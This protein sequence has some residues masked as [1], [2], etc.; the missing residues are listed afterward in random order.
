MLSTKDFRIR[1]PFILAHGESGTYYL[2]GTTDENVW[3]GPAV[4]FDVYRSRDLAEW[5]GPFPAFRP[6]PGFWA[7]RQFWAPEVFAYGGRYYM[8]ASFKAE[9][10][11]RGTQVL[12]A[13]GPSGPY[14][15]LTGKPLTPPDWE[16]L[17]GTLYVD[18]DGTPWMVFC[19]EWLQVRDGKMCAVP[20]TRDLKER[21]G[22][23]VVLFA[24]SSAPWV[25]PSREGNCVTDGPFLY[26][27]EDGQ[28]L[29]LWSSIGEKGY[30]MGIAR[31]E[32][33]TVTG[34]WVHD[35]EPLFGEDGGHGMLFRTFGGELAM[36]IHAPNRS[37]H[38]RAVF[39]P[40]REEALLRPSGNHE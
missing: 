19:Q 26:R 4:G 23:P 25:R 33:G 34:P 29:M 9:G 12:A 28:L 21:A 7:D 39:I 35:E 3:S 8:F 18:E 16:C 1:D 13:D 17:D 31:S 24:A 38:E 37:P 27:S 22:E 15:P 11:A 32:T 40:V 30:A 6:E 36:A 10:A 20:L 14:A 2:F 5:E